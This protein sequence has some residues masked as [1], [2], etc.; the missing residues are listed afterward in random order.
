[1]GKS[2]HKLSASE[3]RNLAKESGQKVHW[4]EQACKDATMDDIDWNFVKD[5]FVARYESLSA[6]K[7]TGNGN[8][9]L[10][11]LNCIRDGNPTNAG[12][13]LFAK[14]PQKFF[15]NAYIAMARYKGK[16][17]GIERMDYKEFAGN[18]FSQIDGCDSYIKE[19]TAMMSR[20]LPQ[21]VERED[22]PEYS[23][24]SV[25]E[26]VTNAVCHRDYSDQGSK[27]IVKMFGDR[28]EFY[29][30]GGL[31]KGITPNNIAERQ[32]SRNPVITKVLAKV[33]YIEDLGEGWDKILK[34]HK[35]HPLS[36]KL[37]LIKADE[38]SVLVAMYSTRDKFEKG[39]FGLNDR[40]KL[41]IGYARGKGKITNEEYQKAGNTT[42]KTA[43]RDLQDMVKRSIFIRTG[44]T[45]KG[46]YYTLNP[47]FKGDIRG[48]KET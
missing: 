2:R 24:F 5:F 45:G 3:I 37:P 35:A 11:A 44:R 43:T 31:Q 10:R 27:T 23:W 22:I 4:D 7:V 26:L 40:Q 46:V 39:S 47:S 34:E 28:I 38:Y 33:K 14:N 20:I 8:D 18:L 17:E 1:M 30:P 25:R 15:A 48:Q 6:A 19:H 12:I 42:K 21:R 41:A 32:Y 36:P 13:L 16:H 29:N 9:L